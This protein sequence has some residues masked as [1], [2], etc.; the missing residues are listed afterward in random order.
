LGEG[1]FYIVNWSSTSCFPSSSLGGC[2]YQEQILG[3]ISESSFEH[4][5]DCGAMFA[6][7]PA[8]HCTAFCFCDLTI[9]FISLHTVLKNS[10]NEG[11]LLHSSCLPGTDT[12]NQNV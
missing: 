11:H 6:S 10:L 2:H 5:S 7:L 9:T 1:S 12:A 8:Y 3:I 4:F